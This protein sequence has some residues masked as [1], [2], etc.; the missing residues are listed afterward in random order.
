MKIV[1]LPGMDGTGL[2]LQDFASLFPQGT[3]QIISYP[4]R[5]FLN[6]DQLADYVA[7]RLPTEDFAL[8]IESF[9]GIVGYKIIERQPRGLKTAIFAA[10]FISSPMPGF[11]RIITV[12][13][14]FLMF[15][16]IF[17]L[18]FFYLPI[19][20]FLVRYLLVGPNAST[21]LVRAV[22]HTL[23][24]VSLWVMARRLKVVAMLRAPTQGINL[25]C[26]Y[27]R[28]KQDRLVPDAA[29]NAFRAL[30]PNF[31][32]HELDGPHFILQTHGQQC[33]TIV[34]QEINQS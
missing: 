10:S 17:L 29:L 16:F 7:A 33:K 25:R 4:R 24:V 27:I 34:E 11:F 8:I 18:L 2:L 23:R 6:P 13:Q 15:F 19:P 26:S 9:S 21:S 3:V 31:T 1:I 30:I 14:F 5:E 20:D 22:E 32:L 12:L 28:P